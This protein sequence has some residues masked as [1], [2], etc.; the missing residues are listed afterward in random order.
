M[1]FVGACFNGVVGLGDSVVE[2]G[3]ARHVVYVLLDVLIDGKR[4]V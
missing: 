4:V 2:F 3:S 1:G